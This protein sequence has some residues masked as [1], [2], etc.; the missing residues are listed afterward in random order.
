MSKTPWRWKMLCALTFL[1]G[2]LLVAQ[3]SAGSSSRFE[4]R[5]I[6]LMPTAGM[7]PKGSYALNVDFYQGGGVL[8]GLSAGI[9]DRF[10]FGVSYGGS[11]LLGYDKPVMNKFPGLFLKLRLV[12][13]S[14]GWPALALG[15]DSQGMNGYLKDLERYAVK[16]PGL[17]AVIS[18]N[19][20][21]AG[22]FSLHGGVNY[23]FEHGDGDEDI[24]VYVGAEK[25]LGPF[26]SLVAEYNLAL[27]DNSQNAIGRGRG[28]LNFALR[29][30]LGG[31]VTVGFNLEDLLKN[32]RAADR[33]NRT[34]H[35]ELVARF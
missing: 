11:S 35:F 24:N 13:E 4:P 33:I 19:Y 29:A 1:G 21:L 16:S 27:N 32:S 5:T 23:S 22:F 25:T 28:Y 20:L 2:P 34:A 14:V 15:F 6:V 31:G 3:G 7:L 8:L 10:C 26:L 30:S 17:Y 9:F 18:K 12:E